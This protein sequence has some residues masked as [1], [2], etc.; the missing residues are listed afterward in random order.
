MVKSELD[1]KVALL[2]EGEQL[3]FKFPCSP[4]YNK[5]TLSTTDNAWIN[6]YYNT[7]ATSFVWA[8]T[9]TIFSVP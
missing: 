3:E 2:A 1:R 5:F 9:S 7:L 4:L 8:K 6:N